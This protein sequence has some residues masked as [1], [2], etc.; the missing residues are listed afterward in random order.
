LLKTTPMYGFMNLLFLKT[1]EK[2]PTQ[3]TDHGVGFIAR[4]EPHYHDHDD[5]H[6]HHDHE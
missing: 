4:E 6:E 5:D 3:P 2:R 1:I